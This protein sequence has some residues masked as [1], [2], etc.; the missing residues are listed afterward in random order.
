MT[1]CRCFTVFAHRLSLF[2]IIDFTLLPV[3]LSEIPDERLERP[4]SV[5]KCANVIMVTRA[6]VV[7]TNI[8]E[9]L[10]RMLKDPELRCS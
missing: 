1:S 4:L 5:R 8:W 10:N 9:E 6:A 3:R 2:A 7:A